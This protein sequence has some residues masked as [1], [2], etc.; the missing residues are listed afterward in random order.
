MTNNYA[1]AAVWSR[2]RSPVQARMEPCRP[3][4]GLRWLKHICLQLLVVYTWTTNVTYA[5]TCYVVRQT[6]QEGATDSLIIAKGDCDQGQG[7][8]CRR[9]PQASD[10]LITASTKYRRTTTTRPTTWVF[11]SHFTSVLLWHLLS[12]SY[13][14]RSELIGILLVKVSAIIETLTKY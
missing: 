2:P 3:P 10:A 6:S 1:C 11:H 13:I 12:L 14:Q 8:E 9:A 4:R 7:D 5:V